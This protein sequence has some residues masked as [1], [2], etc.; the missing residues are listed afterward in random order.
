MSLTLS[1]KYVHCLI[2]QHLSLW[3]LSQQSNRANPSHDVWP[4]PS[5]TWGVRIRILSSHPSS[6][7][8]DINCSCFF[9][10]SIHD[11]SIKSILHLFWRSILMKHWNRQIQGKCPVT[12]PI[13]EPHTTTVSAHRKGW[14]WA[15]V[16]NQILIEPASCCDNYFKKNGIFYP[17]LLLAPKGHV[18]SVGHFHLSGSQF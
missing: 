9:F 6:P 1:K 12:A 14:M 2:I 4:Q 13:E 17:E 16:W 15:V 5:T 3:H 7:V 18:A 8:Y 11:L 10:K